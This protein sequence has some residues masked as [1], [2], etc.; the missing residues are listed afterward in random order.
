[1]NMTTSASWR[2]RVARWA[3]AAAITGLFGTIVVTV[4]AQAATL[5]PVDLLSTSATN[6]KYLDDNTEPCPTSDLNSWTDPSFD[7]SGW[8]SAAG[9]FGAKNGTS[10]INGG[11]IKSLLNQYVDP[12]ASTKTDIPTYF[13]RTTFQLDASHLDKLS[14]LDASI[15]YDDAI[16]V[17][18]NGK[19][20][21]HYL[22]DRATSTTTNLQYAGESG[23]D[24]ATSSFSIPSDAVHSGT[25]TVA[26][27]LYQ[28]RASSS[29]IY[30]D[31]AK[32]TATFDSATPAPEISD[33]SL[34]VG[35][36]QTQR[37]V[38]WYSSLDVAQSVQV[39]PASA[40]SGDSFPTA[41]A[42][43]VA[44]TDGGAATQSGTFWRH[45]T[46]GGIV[47]ATEYVYR[48]G[49]DA[50]WSPVRHFTTEADD[51]K[52]QF[53]AFGDVQIG[54]SGNVASDQA[55]W[56]A[57]LAKA[58]QTF[59]GTD[60]I[61]SLG[62]QVNTANNEAQY[63][64]FLAPSQLANLPVA[65]TIGNH[66]VS[67]L[68]Y[69]QHFNMPNVDAAHG[70]AGNSSSAGGDYW[71]VYGDAL[72]MNLNSNNTDNASHREFLEK[73]IAA[74]GA[75]ARWK[76]VTF[77]HS[78]Y[79]TASHVSDSDIEARRSALPTILS[80]LDIDLVMMGHDHV[81]A[82][83][84]LI[85]DGSVSEDTTGGAH[86]DVTAKKGDVLYV[87][88]N[89]ASG[90]KY[91]G[92]TGSYPWSAVTNQDSRP[93]YTE[94][95]VTKKAISL[96]TVRTDDGSVVDQVALHQQ[97]VTKPTISVPEVNA[98]GLDTSFDPLS[99]VSAADD[100]DGDLTSAISVTGQVD[101]HTVGSYELTYTVTDAAGNQASV[102]RTV[103]VA[104]AAFT[105]SPSPTLTGLAKV[106]STLTAVPGTWDS[107]AAL[108]YQWLLDGKAI[109]GAT[110]STLAVGAG[111]SGHRL[112]AQVTGS[113][114]GY[115]S[116]TRTS[117]AVTVAPGS[118]ARI[119]KPQ[120]SG[121]ARVGKTL[122][123]VPGRWSPTP[124]FSYR[125]LANGKAI[126]GATKATMKLTKKL[127]GKRISV[128]VVGSKPGYRSVVT[129]S[130]RTSAVRR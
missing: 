121:K 25:N 99:G 62:D 35:A 105:L 114:S 26:V 5:D 126:S 92:I 106:G 102:K 73:T 74:H 59:P 32:L 56:E 27:A 89:S 10:T 67:S 103:T 57:T 3:A 9:G 43:T 84:W 12:S 54:A 14:S 29:D 120:I 31:F 64:A 21:A 1:M 85:N 108:T 86:G 55:G 16:R 39:A 104:A 90:S 123:A 129:V 69:S 41:Q 66:D 36:T 38:S 115:Q 20:V 6:W 34:N 78:I 37:N 83:T 48:V 96:K 124:T 80:D 11:T 30:L 7:D 130:A 46:V 49:S 112:S 82:R 125:W 87:T 101:T 52:T 19:L 81:Y 23:S 53:L 47:P 127:K 8:K 117:A 122:K 88:G 95:T 24:P 65:T 33:I 68:A 72:Y 58:G 40:M 100:T 77:H 60:F 91:Y 4:P 109:S 110:R 94:V 28:D 119:V 98:V 17:Y 71:F 45:A 116:L 61:L 42:T 107:H 15:S 22:D 44:A 111:W 63:D 79:S 50:R 70:A 75:D 76:I 18:V 128:I 51:D 2:P 93:S 113:A 13:F 97:D 118:F